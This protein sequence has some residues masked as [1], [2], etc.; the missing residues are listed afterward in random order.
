MRTLLI[1]PLL[2]GACGEPDK[3]DD[4]APPTS[5]DTAVEPIDSDG[6]GYSAD[7]DCDDQDPTIHP[8]A[9][10][11]CNGVDDDCDDEVDE[12]PVDPTTWYTDSDGDGWGD[13]DLTTQAC[14]QPEGAVADGTDC[15]DDAPEINPAADEICWD[16]IDN[17]CD[18]EVDEPCV[19]PNDYP[20]E[21]ADAV[22]Y[23]PTEGGLAGYSVDSA[24]DLNADGYDDLLIGIPEGSWEGSELDGYYE[25]GSQTGA[26]AIVLGPITGDLELT[27]ADAWVQGTLM[28]ERYWSDTGFSVAGVGDTNGDGFDDVLIGAPGYFAWEVW[29]DGER[30]GMAGLILGP[31][32]GVDHLRNADATWHLGGY[33]SSTGYEVAGAGD[34]NGDGLADILIG[35]PGGDLADTDAGEVYIL[36]GPIMGDLASSDL[37]SLVYSDSYDDGTGSVT[38]GAGDVNGDGLDDILIG[39]KNDST[40]MG[41]RGAAYVVL[42]PVSGDTSLADAHLV[43]RGQGSGD[44]LGSAVSSAGDL[45]GDG[46]GD[47]ALG[48]SGAT[49]TAEWGGAVYLFY[50][51]AAGGTEGEST[52]AAATT[53]MYGDT[54]AQQAGDAIAGTGDVDGDGRGDLLIGTAKYRHMHGVETNSWLVLSPSSGSFALGDVAR[55]R[56]TDS[57][58]SDQAG[59]AVSFAGDVDDDGLDDILIGAPGEDSYG[60]EAGAAYLILAAGL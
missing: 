46:Y 39:A 40:T 36:T 51:D 17:D 2:L 57:N 23:G 54:Y 29:W 26:V 12:D 48:V 38:S 56:F 35:S 44:H 20:L 34:V 59:V 45:D 14:E 11:L 42:S 37:Q 31:I 32:S 49:V 58:A 41:G 55:T 52:P 8:D 50:G 19:I 13:P 53:V 25:A 22:L 4:T 7:I 10:E 15:D 3:P 6:D 1:I 28:E 18:D 33:D 9:D 43:V 60:A 24:G 27:D 47:F 21:G 30:S 5:D 16:A